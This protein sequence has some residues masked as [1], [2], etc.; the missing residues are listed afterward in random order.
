MEKMAQSNN[1]YYPSAL[2]IG[3][4]D[5]GGGAGIQAD[6]RTF[7]AF[8]V[9]G[10]SAITALTAQNPLE[11]TRVDEVPVDGVAEQIERVFS[12]IGVKTVKT[13]MLHN[14]EVVA[15]VADILSGRK[16]P[17][18]VD[19]VMVSTSGVRLLEEVSI[20]HLLRVDKTSR[21]NR[22]DC[23]NSS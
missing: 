17:L 22:L 12:V 4:S 8:G 1:Q 5:S 13:G 2:T 23:Q 3:G 9:F 16:L 10:C 6:L 14:A 21:Q 18:V 15:K 11:V 7:A 20:D 19:P